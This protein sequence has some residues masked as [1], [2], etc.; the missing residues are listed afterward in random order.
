MAH[1][2]DFITGISRAIEN[3]KRRAA[4]DEDILAIISFG[5][6]ARKESHSDVDVCLV[7]RPK[8]HEELYMSEKRLGYLTFLGGDFDVQ[9]FQQLPLYVRIRVIREGRVELCKDEPA[10]YDLAFQ[11]IK[12]FEQFEHIYL[13]YLEAVAND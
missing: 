9:V 10:L 13:D 12:D 7:M 3:L 6:Y 5:S 8:R 11:T 2:V 1:K 4:Q